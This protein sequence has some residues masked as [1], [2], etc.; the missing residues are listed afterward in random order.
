LTLRGASPRK[1]RG[2]GGGKEKNRLA[3]LMGECWLG[4]PLVLKIREGKIRDWET[5]SLTSEASGRGI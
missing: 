2:W 4:R 1:V 3:L 5:V